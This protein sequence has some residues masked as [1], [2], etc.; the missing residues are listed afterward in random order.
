MV[1][2]ELVRSTIDGV[3]LLG[4]P[5]RPG[6]VTF[7]FA[8]RTGGVS[9]GCFSSLNLGDNTDDDPQS[10]AENRRRALAALGA[11]SLYRRLVAPRQVHGT[12][13]VVVEDSHEGLARAKAEARE[14]ADAVVCLVPNVPVL[15]CM[16]DCATVVLATRGAFAVVHAGWRGCLSRIAGKA[17]DILVRKTGCD[18]STIRAYVGP[19]IGVDDYE[20]SDDLA[21]RFESEFGTRVLGTKNHVSL[22][23]SILASLEEAGVVTSNIVCAPESTFANEYR[24]FSF[25][26]QQG[27]CGRMGALACILDDSE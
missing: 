6:G 9:D 16:A 27:S 13:V 17:A 10:V 15:V 3:T 18:A 5:N 26:R 7:A 14:G 12:N 8:E 23:Q 19:H 24:Y 2:P 11:G 1:A 4:D 25:R 22:Y 21:K 20:V